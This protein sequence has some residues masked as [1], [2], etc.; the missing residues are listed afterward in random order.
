MVKLS[1]IIPYYKTLEY[2][3]ELLKQ[4]EDQITNEVEVLVVDD[5]T[6]DMIPYIK[7][8]T[9]IRLEEN[10]GGA[11]RPRNIGID[12][13][14]GEYITFIDSDDMVSEDYISQIL[15]AIEKK[16]DIVF[17]SWKSKVQE[18]IMQIRPPRWN[19]SVWC[20]VYKR[21]IIGN[22]R[23]DESLR[24]AEDWKFNEQ[25]KYNTKVCIKKVIYFYNNGRKG[26]I[27]NG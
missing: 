20:R 4:L 27:L 1:I 16:P 9:I 2:T 23:F 17:L 11:S 10:S 7:H 12:M 24:I 3:K 25:I 21:D 6:D 19:C 5:G 26:S 13:A 18:I 15:K 22:I 8:G 14:R